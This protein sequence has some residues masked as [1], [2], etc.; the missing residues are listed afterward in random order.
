METEETPPPSDISL[1]SDRCPSCLF[2]QPGK[3]QQILPQF[4]LHS[5]L[6]P[7]FIN[8][9]FFFSQTDKS[10][11]HLKYKVAAGG[12]RSDHSKPQSSI[13]ASSPKPEV[14]KREDG[15]EEEQEVEWEEEE[16]EEEEEDTLC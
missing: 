13:Q 7:N 14:D 15:V 12:G 9:F 4:H 3:P 5:T 2:G 16:E 6:P 11:L 10:G 8:L 1:G